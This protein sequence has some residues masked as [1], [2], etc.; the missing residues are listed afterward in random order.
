VNGLGLQQVVDPYLDSLTGVLRNIPGA[1]TS[2]ELA[3]L[4]VD[5]SSSR[6]IQLLTYDLVPHTGD[7]AE[8]QGIHKH[9]FQDLF[10]WAGEL[11]TIDMKRGS[12]K[13]FAHHSGIRTNSFHVFAAL[14]DKKSLRELKRDEFVNELANFYDQLN[15]IHP[16]R[17]GN[18][19]T[20]RLFWSRIA[21]NAG[22]VLDWRPIH[23]D[24]LDEVSRAAREEG[25]L[26]SLRAALTL[27]VSEL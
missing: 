4:E 3:A 23:G 13:F 1:S 12:G 21:L 19:R 22:W 14:R 11:R 10:D 26:E 8:V 20:Q 2:R 18:G 5:L 7:L 16:F 17:D 9:L 27:C 24:V 6:T 15:F 25:D